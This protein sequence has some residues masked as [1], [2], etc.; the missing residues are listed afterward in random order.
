MTSVALMPERCNIPLAIETG[1]SSFAAAC[2][3]INRIMRERRNPSPRY[4]VRH[5]V[6][7]LL[8][9]DGCRVFCEL[10]DM[11]LS[12][13]RLAKVPLKSI[14]ETFSF[15]ISTED[16]VL[17]C[18]VRWTSTSEIGVEFTGEPEF[19]DDVVDRLW[20]RRF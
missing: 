10:K 20:T 15:L 2:R 1:L 14:P 18:R 9:Q 17:P 8:D 12:G 19:R 7:L 11:S 16:V 5:E 6:S 13:A 3:C 4:Q